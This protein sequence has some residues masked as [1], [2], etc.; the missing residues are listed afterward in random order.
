MKGKEIDKLIEVLTEKYP[1]V[2]DID[3][4][5]GFEGGENNAVWIIE[6]CDQW[7]SECLNADDILQLA[8]FLK[9]LGMKLK[10]GTNAG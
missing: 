8:D 2:K 5:V 7:Y 1:V 9:E 4:V 10:E 3:R 6:Q